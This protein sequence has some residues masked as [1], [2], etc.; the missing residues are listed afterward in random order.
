MVS[1]LVGLVGWF[2]LLRFLGLF[3]AIGLSVASL[4]GWT[5]WLIP[6]GCLIGLVGSIDCSIR[7]LVACLLDLLDSYGFIGLVG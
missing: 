3:G 7:C 4:I 6:L 5:S 2:D 1:R